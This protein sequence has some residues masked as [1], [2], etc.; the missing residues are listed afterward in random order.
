[1]VQNQNS[2]ACTQDIPQVEQVLSLTNVPEEIRALGPNTDLFRTL[3]PNTDL[4]D[5]I[6]HRATLQS[7]SQNVIS[8]LQQF[9]IVKN[10]NTIIFCAQ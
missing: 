5:L 2:V 10:S 8:A 3:G 4:E 1:M 7:N 9:Q 6:R